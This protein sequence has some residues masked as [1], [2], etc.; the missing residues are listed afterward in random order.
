[1]KVTAVPLV[2]N[3]G[4]LVI[5]RLVPFGPIWEEA[6]FQYYWADYQTIVQKVESGEWQPEDSGTLLL[7][8]RYH[9]LSADNGRIWVERQDNTFTIFFVT[10]Q[11]GLGQFAGYLYRADGRPPQGSGLLGQWRY[12]LPKGPN[13]FYCISG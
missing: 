6:R 9:H 5:L 1:M 4:T 13:W 8:A 3:I 11:K 7:P 12:L 2:I 10:E